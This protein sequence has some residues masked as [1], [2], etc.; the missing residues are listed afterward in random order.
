MLMTPEELRDRLQF[1]LDISRQASSQIMT[2]YQQVQLQ[3]EQ[4]RDLTPVTDADRTAEQLLR[5][6]IGRNYPGD[7]V[8]GEEFGET[9]GQNPIRWILDPIDGTKAFIHGVPLFGTLIG[10]EVEGR[11]ILG[12]C[13]FPALNEVVYGAQ[14]QGAWWQPADGQ[15]REAHVSHAAKLADATV[16][17]TDVCCWQETGRVKKLLRLDD[18][19]ELTRGW[20]DCY[21]HMLV[22]TGRADIMLDPLLNEWDAAAI[23][24]II[25]EAGGHFID[26]KGQ[27]GR[28]AG[29][30]ISVNAALKDDLVALLNG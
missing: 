20:G 27:P 19:A 11:L 1:A 22:A 14:G 26:W 6:E 17:Y 21:G 29:N 18:T 23:V 30:G 9:T 5:D 12:V 7:G 13:R 10:L 25:H 15:P 24:P 2:Y 16:C 8:W 28:G 3:V 4:K